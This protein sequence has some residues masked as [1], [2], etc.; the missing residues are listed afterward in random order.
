MC[1]AAALNQSN[2]PL[3]TGLPP[4]VWGSPIWHTCQIQLPGP[5]PTCVGQPELLVFSVS[6]HEAYP[7]VCGAAMRYFLKAGH[8]L[9]LP[10][11]VWGSLEMSAM[12]SPRAGPTPTCVG[13]P[14]TIAHL[15]PA[16]S[17]YPH[18]CGAAWW[19]CVA[20]KR[21]EGLPPR[22]WGSPKAQANHS[23]SCRPTPTCVG[24]P[25]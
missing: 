11:R 12:Q 19:R 25:V 14:F 10:P 17:A 4:R 6:L 2:S 24:Q 13:Q 22:V 15:F 21:E 16:V 18:V 5:T 23:T 1:G 20:W 8:A 7:H 9:G 3:N